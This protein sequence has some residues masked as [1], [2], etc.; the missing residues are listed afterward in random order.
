MAVETEIKLRLEGGIGGMISKLRTLGYLPGPRELEADQLYDFPDGSL[1]LSGRL[2]RL[3]SRGSRW[4]L[5]Y[6]GPAT[7]GPHK[8][9]EELETGIEDGTTLSTILA[10]LG[11]VPAFR[12]EKYRTTFRRDGEEG[13]VTIDETPIG[14]FL[15]LEGEGDWIDRTATVLGFTPAEYL[16][17]SYSSLYQEY[18]RAH[19]GVRTDMTF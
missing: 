11:Y 5:T 3:R 2:L 12:Y 9:R 4:L 6:K 18:R 1:R 10:A 19:P 7:P 8:S 16:T 13:S 17:A 15:E 14:V